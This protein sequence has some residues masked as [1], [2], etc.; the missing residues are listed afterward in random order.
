M[1]HIHHLEE[2]DLPLCSPLNSDMTGLHFIALATRK[3]GDDE[4][5]VADVL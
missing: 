1:A 2:S 4:T 3:E 5:C